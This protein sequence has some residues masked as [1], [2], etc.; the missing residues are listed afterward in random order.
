MVDDDDDDDDDDGRN[1]DV[2]GTFYVLSITINQS[3]HSTL[4]RFCVVNHKSAV[5]SAGI[6]QDEVDIV[7]KR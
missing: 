2:G 7:V 4:I 5:N 3:I 1:D 6:E